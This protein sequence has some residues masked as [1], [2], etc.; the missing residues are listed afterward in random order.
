M[1]ASLCLEAIITEA[2]GYVTRQF[3]VYGFVTRPH[4]PVLI[5]TLF[6]DFTKRQQARDLQYK[7]TSLLF[8][9]FLLVVF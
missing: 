9:I 2:V 8:A 5:S 7:A 1:T 3:S 6:T 4:Y